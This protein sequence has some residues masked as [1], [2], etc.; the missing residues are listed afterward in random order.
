MN[1]AEAFERFRN[2]D[3]KALEWVFVTYRERFV[4]WAMAKYKLSTDDALTLFVDTLVVFERNTRTKHLVTLNSSIL[5]YLIGVAKMIK[6]GEKPTPPSLPEIPVISEEDKSWMDDNAQLL[7]KFV[8][9]ELDAMGHPCNQILSKFYLEEQKLEAL[10]QAMGYN[11]KDVV[12]SQKLKCLNELTAR[13]LKK[14]PETLSSMAEQC[15]NI[16]TLYFIKKQTLEQIRQVIGY[17]TKE[18]VSERKDACLKDL[19][20]RLL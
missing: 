8:L 5:T 6:L 19:L 13:L 18:Q 15:N 9:K 10:M 1:D 17:D 7:S 3:N 11:N 2:G 4:Y 14:L 12:K 20:K 16:L